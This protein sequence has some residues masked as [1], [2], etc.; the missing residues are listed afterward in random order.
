MEDGAII[1]IDIVPIKGGLSRDE[2]VSF[3]D[4]PTFSSAPSDKALGELLRVPDLSQAVD[5]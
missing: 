4:D 3:S 5:K 1:Y 2:R